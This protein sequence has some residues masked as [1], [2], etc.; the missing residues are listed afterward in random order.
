[1]TDPA[2]VVKTRSSPSRT[3][4]IGTTCGRP[5]MRVVATLPVRVPSATNARHSS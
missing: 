5:S 2:A 1:L 4:Q 3:N